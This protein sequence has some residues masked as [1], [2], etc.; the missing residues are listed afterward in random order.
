MWRPHPPQ[1][2]AVASPGTFSPTVDLLESEGAR[3]AFP[4]EDT[5]LESLGLLVPLC[6]HQQNTARASARLVP[7]LTGD[8]TRQLGVVRNWQHFCRETGRCYESGILCFHRTSDHVFSSTSLL[9]PLTLQRK[10]SKAT[11]PGLKD[12]VVA[13]VT[14]AL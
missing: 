14:V 11:A 1:S 4:G 6:L 3:S 7:S 10:Q 9:T 2:W 13:A 8:V 5:G 12:P